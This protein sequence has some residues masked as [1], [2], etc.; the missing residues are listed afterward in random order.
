MTT[1]RKIAAVALLALMVPGAAQAQISGGQFQ[2]QYV[3]LL[4]NGNFNIAQRGTTTVAAITTTA[5][6]LWDRWAAYSGTAT[7]LTLTNVTSTLPTGFSNAARLQR[8]SGQ[9][10][11]LA[12]YL[13]QEV[14]AADVIPQRGQTVTLSFW[15]RSG[16]NFSAASGAMTVKITTGTTADQGLAT[17]ISGWAGAATPLSTTQVITANWQRFSFSAT[18]GSTVSELAVQLGFVPVGT[19]ST[20]DYLEIVGAQLEL[21]SVASNFEWRSPAL[22]LEKVQYYAWGTT[23]GAATLRYGNCQV[24]SANTTA[25][26]GIQLPRQLR[27]TPT[28]TVGT[29]Q[30]FGLTI[31]NGSAGTCTNLAATSSGSTVNRISLTCTTGATVAITVPSE[32]IGAA[33][34]GTLLASADF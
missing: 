12:S 1:F 11:V 33:T 15:V 3:N 14:P 19:A 13:V 22:E 26:C 21:G 24:I 4:D 17:L 6:Y 23:D 25:V 31:A 28:I 32:F 5:T 16:A 10:G 9:T 34:G 8:T 18:L 7:A 20:N 2:P 30:S 29:A 27:T